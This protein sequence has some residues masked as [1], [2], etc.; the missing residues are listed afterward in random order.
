V[1]PVPAISSIRP[2]AA[3]VGSG[4]VTL[5]LSG[6]NFVSNS[7]VLLNGSPRP[8]VFVSSNQ[9]TA[10]LS[11]IDTGGLGN[12]SITVSNPAPGGGFSGIASFTTFVNVPAAD[13]VYS[14][15]TQ[16][17]YASLPSNA[18][19]TL[20]NSVVSI[21]PFTGALGAP[22]YVGSEPGKMAISS[23]GGTVW[24]ALNGAGAVRQVNLNTST[25]GLQFSLGGGNGVYN[26]PRTA[27]ALAILPGHPDTVAV[28]TT[29][30]FS[31]VTTIYDSGVP[32]TNTVSAGF[33]CCGLSFDSTGTKLFGAGTGYGVATADGSGLS[34]ATLLNHNV[35]TNALRIDNGRAYLTNGTVLDANSGTLLGT[36][37]VNSTT[38]VSGPVAPDSVI[39]E[40][41]VLQ[42]PAFGIANQF[43]VYDLSSFTLK[44]TF[45]V[46]VA[47]ADTN[48]MRW[49]QDGLAF[50]TGSAV[51][52]LR[53][54]SVRDLSSSLADLNVSTS[55]AA[56]GISGNSFT[57][58]LTVQN[59]GPLATT[60]AVLSDSIP[61][62][63]IVQ[64]ITTSQGTCSGTS[65]VLCDLGNLNSAASAN[66][67]I[68][69]I[70]SAP[71]ILTNTAFVSAPEGDPNFAN[72]TS[73]T[74]V[75]VNGSPYNPT[76]SLI[77]ISPAF[78]QTGSPSF[79]I[80][81]NGSNFVAGSVVQLNSTP[82][83]TSFVSASKLTATVDATYVSSMGWSWINVTSPLPG[84]GT[85]SST[86]L[87]TYK[88]ISLDVNRMVF[89]AFTRKLYATL[90][91]TA[92]ATV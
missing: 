46:S 37:S 18:G 33:M 20:G 87:T 11:A 17:L 53:S 26:P 54:T 81:V 6:S 51:F 19:P 75:T 16:L 58:G 67:Q 90:P 59:A 30:Q 39:G 35:S 68:S 85:S 44:S 79:T 13:L 74:T 64:S 34:A 38:P 14:Q 48:L 56:T 41:F 73:V 29:G 60:A 89:D 69:V 71:G 12:S 70:L 82:L 78:A 72:N 63:A 2:N 76:P 45:P 24:V 9:I 57:Y 86:P 28:T 1:N 40:A 23:D 43:Y 7:V 47:S 3:P 92:T 5:S 50:T 49:G 4:A 84:G 83:P 91:S 15:A 66:V 88:V 22:I 65:V 36:L 80:T 42:S 25:A 77:S 21:D 52:A 31:N 10:S 8:T 55:A 27:Q 61:S 62:G 32:R